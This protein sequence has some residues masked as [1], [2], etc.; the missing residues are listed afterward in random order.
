MSQRI[1]YR[2]YPSLLDSFQR[3][4]NPDIEG[5]WWQDDKG[6]WHKNYDE[7]TGDYHYTPQESEEVIYQ[8]LMDAINRVPFVSEAAS[9]GTAFNNAID[10]YKSGQIVIP[11]DCTMVQAES[12]GFKFCFS[13]ALIK[14]IGDRFKGAL[15]Q[16]FTKAV[17]ETRYGNVE[18]YGYIDE[19][20]RDKVYDLKTTG[21]YTFGN[22]E[23]HWQRHVYPYCL[24]KSGQCTEISS[25][26][27]NVI[28]LNKGQIITGR[29]Y[30]EEYTF[31]FEQSE[32]RLREFLERFIEFLNLHRDEITATKLFGDE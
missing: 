5:L 31:N 17:I 9:K 21:S 20:L 11:D 6:G 3:Y 7:A 24:I 8:E 28:Q 23:N 12:D 25:F 22:Y 30:R 10:A 32:K 4:L 13:P 26:E 29:E 14:Q 16:V 2:I 27:Y 19:L 1:D 15:S 18:L